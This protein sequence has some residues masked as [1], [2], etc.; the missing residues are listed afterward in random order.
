V[1]A[2]GPWRTSGEWWLRGEIKEDIAKETPQA[3]ARDEW[4]VAIE[5]MK[6]KVSEVAEVSKVSAVRRKPLSVA[7]VGL[8]R[9]TQETES[10]GWWMEAKYD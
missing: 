7:E 2:A 8:F 10:G 3:W 1:W 6:A 9:M 4:D 5:V